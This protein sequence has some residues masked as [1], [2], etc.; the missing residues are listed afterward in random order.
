[1][2]SRAFAITLFTALAMTVQ[3]LTQASDI[4]FTPLNDPNQGPGGTAGNAINDLG[5]AAGVYLGVNG[6]LY[7][8]VAT[9]PYSNKSFTTVQAAGTFTKPWGINLEGTITAS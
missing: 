8:F 6:V 2:N 1:M 9:P 3:V 4:H 7:G 5:V